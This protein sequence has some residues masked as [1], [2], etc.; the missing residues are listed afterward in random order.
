MTLLTINAGS[1]SVRLGVYELRDGVAREALRARHTL[2]KD[3]DR[4][5]VLTASLA[6][7]GEPVAILH[8]VVI[9]DVG[10]EVALRIDADV[11]RGIE[12]MNPRAPLH[13]PAA[14]S[15]I[16]A[17]RSL[18]PRAVPI[19]VF[20][21]GFFA[22]LPEAAT[23][24]AIPIE[25]RRDHGIRRRG[26][27]GLAHR[28]LWRR[29]CA[30]RPDLPRGGRL[31]S[32]QL[33][34]GASIAAVHQGAPRDTSMGFSPL[35]GLVMATRCGDFDPGALLY[36]LQ[37]EG[38]P[39]DEL[40]HALSFRSGLAGLAES[41]ARIDRLI[42]SDRPESKLAIDV[43]VHR[44]RRYLGAYLN[45]LSGADGIVFGGGVGENVPGIRERALENM[46][47]CGVLLDREAN[48]STV[49][50]EG[51]ISRRDS[52]VEVWVVPVDEEAEMVE[53][54]IPLLPGVTGL[55]RDPRR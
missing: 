11:E 55:H 45:V 28:A 52:A 53:G 4:A 51:R 25:Y 3:F 38:V 54:S 9:G 32:A 39:L 18:F 43:Y 17:A 34:S 6:G 48:R 8:R 35:E 33:G 7:F 27:H 37:A 46:E 15:W 36:L 22:G 40:A 30:A 29:W 49:A 5:E 14:L 12:A 50:V 2:A 1:S 10:D 13:N 16:Q 47:W 19:A 26:S 31:I 42:E 41:D 24:Y 20:D 44:L 23:E 21:T